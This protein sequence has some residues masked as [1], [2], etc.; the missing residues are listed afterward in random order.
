L[1]GFCGGFWHF[2]LILINLVKIFYI[3]FC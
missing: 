1:N 3:F 2:V